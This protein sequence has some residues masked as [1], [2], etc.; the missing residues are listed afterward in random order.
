MFRIS[1]FGSQ[2]LKDILTRKTGEEQVSRNEVT[3]LTNG[4]PDCWKLFSSQFSRI[5]EGP[6]A[7]NAVYKA[8]GAETA[9]ETD[10]LNMLIGYN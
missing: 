8:G 4:R 2:N 10:D 6:S 1:N 7:D 3:N 9:L 5:N